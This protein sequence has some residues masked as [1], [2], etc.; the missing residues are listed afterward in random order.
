M[1]KFEILPV[2]P[3]VISA[4][5]VSEDISTLWEGIENLDFFRSDAD[6]THLV[7]S[8][9]NMQILDTVPAV[10]KLMLNYFYEFKDRVLKL[11]KTDF[12]ITT[13]WITKTEPGGFCCY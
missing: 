10:R 4:V 9:K 13:S 12:N 6:D 5:Q 8:S 2:F 1:H 3:S 11:Q 7:Y